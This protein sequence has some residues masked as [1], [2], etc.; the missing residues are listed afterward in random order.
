MSGW[1]L[2]FA[3]KILFRNLKLELKLIFS[4][5]F[6]LKVVLAQLT[7]GSNS[8]KSVNRMLLLRKCIL[9][10]LACLGNCTIIII[11]NIE[12]AIRN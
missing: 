3:S 5:Q 9:I 11:V 10:A 12:S 6:A 7:L 4:M 2:S 1:N 8:I